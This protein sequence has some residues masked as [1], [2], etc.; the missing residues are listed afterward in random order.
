MAWVKATRKVIRPRMIASV[1]GE[2]RHG[3]TEFGLT[4]PGPIAAFPIDNNTPE[5][6]QKRMVGKKIRIPD[7][8][9]MYSLTD[10]PDVWKASWEAYKEHYTEAVDDKEIRTIM[11]DT[12]TE[13]YNL[14]RLALLGKLK[15][16]PSRF[17]DDVNAEWKALLGMAYASDKNFI[18]VHQLKDVY[19]GKDRT[20]ER[21]AAGW[22]Q[23]G[24][25]VQLDLLC[26]RDLEYRDEETGSQGFGISIINCTQNE[27]LAGTFLQEPENN[28]VELGKLVYPG[29]TD[30]DWE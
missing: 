8:N 7:V 19:K 4:A 25:K 6:I 21:T 17:Y 14:S 13:M 2:E 22:G 10:D 30:E 9:L 11:T 24:Y 16:V 27:T 1:K 18:F 23:M 12:A 15:E 20:G 26:W 29:T 3:K 28:W 5:M